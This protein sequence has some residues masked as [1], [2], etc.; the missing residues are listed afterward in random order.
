LAQILEE[1]ERKNPVESG[2]RKAKHHQWLTEDVGH[3]ALA[4][5]LHAVITLMRVSKTWG[6]FKH[7]LDLA[8]PKRGDTLQLLLMAD[9]PEPTKPTDKQASLFDVTDKA[10]R[11]HR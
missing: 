1:L 2:R 4:Q 10:V 11:R 6:Q 8:H 9:I 5:H 3:S 7:M